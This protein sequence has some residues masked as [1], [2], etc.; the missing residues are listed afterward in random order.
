MHY[1]CANDVGKTRQG[2]AFIIDEWNKFKPAHA[3]LDQLWRVF[4]EIKRIDKKGKMSQGYL[5][6]IVFSV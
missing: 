6:D 1:L 4:A 3:T 5:L 2:R